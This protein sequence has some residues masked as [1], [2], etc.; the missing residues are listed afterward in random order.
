MPVKCFVTGPEGRVAQICNMCIAVP[1]ETKKTYHRTFFALII[2]DP[3]RSSQTKKING[4]VKKK[5]HP[6]NNPGKQE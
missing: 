5:H 2:R 4:L 1:H 3:P 6:L